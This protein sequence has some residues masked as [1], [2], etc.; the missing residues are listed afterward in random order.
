MTKRE[1]IIASVK[2]IQTDLTPYYLSLTH[3]EFE[4]VA[5][6]FQDRNFENEIGS[7]ITRFHYDGFLKEITP[8]SGYWKDDFSVVWNRNGAD[9][10]IGVIDGCVITEPDMEKYEFPK[11]D[12]KRIRSEYEALIAKKDD[13]FKLGSIGFAV[14]E[15]AW[16]LRGMENILMDM[17]LEPD[18]ADELLDRITDYNLKII[19]I[20]LEYDIDGFH[21]GDDWGQQRGLIMG[22]DYWRRFIKPR[23]ARLYDRIK[24]KGLIVSHHSCGDVHEIFPDLIEIGLDIYNPL[25]P[26][27][28]DLQK[29]KREYGKDLTFWGGISTQRLLPFAAPEKIKRVV[30]ETIKIMGEGGG[31]IVAPTHS[32]P[33]DVPPENIAAM[34]EVFKNQI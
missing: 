10:D 32:V 14:F 19:D 16:T 26:E 23:M 3:Q 28:Y 24:S 2:H 21:F 17:I 4:K 31:F 34:V 12:E 8:G 13:T 29:I 1:R 33:G 7:H 20:A 5:E 11:L 30:L 25:Q 9:K 27:I 22:P 15:R 6:Y 18:F